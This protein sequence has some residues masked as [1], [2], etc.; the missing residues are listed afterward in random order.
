VGFEC[1]ACK[2]SNKGHTEKEKRKKKEK[3]ANTLEWDE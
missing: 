3:K 2:A 1:V